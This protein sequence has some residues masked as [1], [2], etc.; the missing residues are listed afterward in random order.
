[1]NPN[2]YVFLLIIGII[3][4]FWKMFQVKLCVVSALDWG[5]FK[6]LLCNLR[7]GYG[8]IEDVANLHVFS[9]HFQPIIYPLAY[10]SWILPIDFFMAFVQTA[11]LI[12]SFV[13]AYAFARKDDRFL[14]NWMILPLVFV[15]YVGDLHRFDFHPEVIAIPFIVLML[16][17]IHGH[18]KPLALIKFALCVLVVVS[19]KETASI[20]LIGVAITAVLNR[21]YR[22][23]TIALVFA[24]STF[25]LFSIL[26]APNSRLVNSRYGLDLTHDS[27]IS[28][29]KTLFRNIFSFEKL[30]HLAKLLLSFGLAFMGRFAFISAL[31]SILLEMSRRYST[32]WTFAMQYSTFIIPFAIFGAAKA[33]CHIQAKIHVPV[34]LLIASFQVP[35]YFKNASFQH[36]R[37][38]EQ[39]VAM[40]PSNASIAAG[41]NIFP[42][43]CCGRFGRNVRFL[44]KNTVLADYDYVIIDGRIG[45]FPFDD[46]GFEKF[47]EEISCDNIFEPIFKKDSIFVFRRIDM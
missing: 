26:V 46:S 11:S 3:W 45:R 25:V 38:I 7:S 27:F 34:V 18:E 23:F 8:A 15:F 29:L 1:M 6:S 12:L 24:L 22:F 14:A 13:I 47:L 30:V 36:S 40:M 39:A 28:I 19:V 42:K 44:H 10:L 4:L 35:E 17:A 9:Q 41:S 43:I 2:G 5:Y 31:P 16:F 32:Q 21:K 33:K 37:Y 20:A